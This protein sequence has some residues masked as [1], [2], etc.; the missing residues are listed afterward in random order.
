[1]DV[2]IGSYA[3]FWEW[4][5]HPDPIGIEGM[6]DRAAEL[7]CTVFEIC[8]DP[9]IEDRSAHGLAALRAR[10]A[11]LDLRL[12]LGT[13]GIDPARLARWVDMAEA[14]DARVLRSMVQRPD[15]ARGA[16]HVAETLGASLPRLE[17]AGVALALETYEQVP[18]AT[19]VG[20]IEAV[21]SPLVGATLDPANCIAALERPVDVVD[22]VAP[23]AL[24][25]HVKDF[26]FDRQPG[27]V[28]FQLTGARMGSGQLD[29]QHELDA[30]HAAGRAPA[31]IVEHWL[32]WQGTSAAS[33]ALERDWTAATL[34]ALAAWTPSP[35]PTTDEGAA[36]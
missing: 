30:V 11:D 4:H 14:L 18:T 28:G 3:M 7:G 16:A 26:R 25:L 24:D 31:A 36:R 9:R 8:D 17:A 15:A 13:R 12:Q 27:W 1:M 19:L 10:A 2:G 35:I 29:V 34:A 6:L 5:D 32:P 33:V 20:A 23:H 22:A 21:G